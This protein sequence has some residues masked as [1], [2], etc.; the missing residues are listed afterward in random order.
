M[1]HKFANIIFFFIHG[2]WK[3]VHKYLSIAINKTG[4]NYTLCIIISSGVLLLFRSICTRIISSSIYFD[5]EIGFKIHS[6]IC[7]QAKCF[8]SALWHSSSVIQTEVSII[9]ETVAISTLRCTDNIFFPFDFDTVLKCEWM[10]NWN[11][12]KERER[13]R[14]KRQPREIYRLDIR[15]SMN[16]QLCFNVSWH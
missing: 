9:G 6:V 15:I 2:E 13:E 8:F 1:N 3:C 14:E 5:V 11:K 12:S 16:C 7:L 10:Y 4:L